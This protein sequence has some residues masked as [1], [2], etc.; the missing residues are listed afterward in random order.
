MKILFV[1]TTPIE[2][3]S[4]ANMRNIG[5][6][7]GLIELGHSVT[8]VSARPQNKSI[9]VDNTLLSLNLYERFY[10]ES[11]ILYSSL[12]SSNKKGY[13]KNKEIINFFRKKVYKII[14]KLS[15]YDPRKS[16][17]SGV[18][19]LKFENKKYDL[20]IS[21]SDPKSSHLLAAEI[22]KIFPNVSRK[23]VQYWGDPFAAD[24]NNKTLLP[25]FYIKKQELKMLEKADK[26]VY[27]SPFT[28]QQQE[29]FYPHLKGKFV[30]IPT[31]YIEPIV[32]EKLND[33]NKLT[34][35]YF[36]DYNSVDRNILPL[37]SAV[38]NSTSVLHIYGR[39]DNH[40]LNKPNILVNDRVSYDKVK[41]MEAKC[42]VLICICNKKGTQIP[43]KIYH[44]AATN[45][46]ILI[47]LDGEHQELM[48]RYFESF[49][50]YIIC[51]NSIDS[52]L[53][54]L[55]EISSNLIEYAPLL[56]FDP[57]TIA[58]EFLQKV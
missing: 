14:S 49:K 45:K 55:G 13:K 27:V 11:S 44:Y 30:F 32:H 1:L 39:G 15:L 20:M 3:N 19:N 25:D 29:E 34:I 17:I 58:E 12:T 48:R 8:I 7:K 22:K 33:N 10:L 47:I 9:Y 52:I 38:M 50:R 42:D 51:E 53:K 21:S 36:G 16:F 56:R 54:A 43:G 2:Y 24:I 5:L 6:I 26:V 37:C 46:P 35:G 18:I 23:W 31:P 40:I 4:S 28:L 41:L 57:K